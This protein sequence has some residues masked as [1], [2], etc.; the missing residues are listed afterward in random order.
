MAQMKITIIVA[1]MVMILTSHDHDDCYHDADRDDFS[2]G[3][4]RHTGVGLDRVVRFG[5][6]SRIDDYALP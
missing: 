6:S 2:T 1:I 5:K 4:S 3:N